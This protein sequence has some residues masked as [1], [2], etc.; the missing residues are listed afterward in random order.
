[1]KTRAP[2]KPKASAGKSGRKVPAPRK[3]AEEKA[4]YHKALLATLK[5][6]KK[7]VSAK[8]LRAEVGGNP[9]QFLYIIK[10]MLKAKEIK[11]IGERAQRAY[12]LA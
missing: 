2:A 10:Q 5:R 12:A 6:S 9:N 11:A 4:A 1:M 7:P 8:N 3:S